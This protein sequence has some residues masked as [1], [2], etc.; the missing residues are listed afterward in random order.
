V[1]ANDL[2]EDDRSVASSHTVA[3]TI[4]LYSSKEQACQ[5][6]VEH[7]KEHV[8]SLSARLRAHLPRPESLLEHQARYLV[9]LPAV[10]EDFRA[11]L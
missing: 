7:F 9:L 8:A 3:T 5:L 2:E 10:R 4:E 1:S 6:K 11:W